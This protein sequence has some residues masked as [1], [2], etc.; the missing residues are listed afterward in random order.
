[1]LINNHI[2][3]ETGEPYKNLREIYDDAMSEL[4]LIKP[5]LLNIYNDDDMYL[6]NHISEGVNGY[7]RANANG[8]IAY[9][10]KQ[11]Y[12][13][14][15]NKSIYLNE[16]VHEQSIFVEFKHVLKYGFYDD[17]SQHMKWI[18]P[19]N[20]NNKIL[21]DPSGLPTYIYVWNQ[22]I[23]T[24][25]ISGRHDDKTTTF[26]ENFKAYRRFSN[27]HNSVLRPLSQEEMSKWLDFGW[28]FPTNDLPY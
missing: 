27:D 15:Y 25:K 3:K 9:K 23:P 4:T 21:I 26:E 16:N 13:L 8:Q 14:D 1:M 24:Y 18:L 12:V 20:D 6:P 5:D 11:S 7:L 22:D 19:L 10:P 28:Y 2:S 17:V